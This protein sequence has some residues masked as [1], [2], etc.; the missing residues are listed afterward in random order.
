MKRHAL[1]LYWVICMALVCPAFAAPQHYAIGAETIAAA[2]SSTG[3]QTSP[4]EVSLLASVVATT[5]TPT[6]EVRF[7]KGTGAHQLMVR[8]ECAKREEC[9]PFFVEIRVSPG[10][11]AQLPMMLPSTPSPRSASQFQPILVRTGSPATLELDGG[12]IH[13]RIPVI[14]LDNG[15][16][17]LTVRA[18]DKESRRIYTA[19]VTEDGLLKGRL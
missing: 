8:L 7:L 19:Q 1:I 2:I 16:L 3:I 9:L 10:R 18:I 6:L 5:P 11:E 15:S 4:D 12:H 14:C 17:G 13:I